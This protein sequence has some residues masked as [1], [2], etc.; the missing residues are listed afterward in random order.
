VADWKVLIVYPRAPEAWRAGFI[1][2]VE[3]GRWIVSLSGY[4]G[5]HPPTDEPGFLEF[6]RSLSRPDIH[7][8]LRGA[9]PLTEP[10]THKI[11][12]SRWL[13]YERMERFPE[14]FILLGD[15]VCAFN[16]IYGQGMTVISMGMRRLDELLAAQGHASPGS[17][18]GFS[19][20]FQRELAGLLEMPWLMSSTM[21]LK[22]PQ[23]SGRRPPGQRLLQWTFGTM[24]DLTSLDEQACR[25]FYEVMNMRHGAESLLRPGFLKTFLSY[26]VKSFFV[27]LDQRANVSTRPPPPA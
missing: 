7:E 19:R 16:P 8:A 20:R 22:Y 6:A 2:R 9:R 5:D 3:G 14:N 10:V 13:H 18:Q 1:S 23:A 25:R 12:S 26:G 27:P 11:P 4:F 21:D 15:S 17:L 24:I